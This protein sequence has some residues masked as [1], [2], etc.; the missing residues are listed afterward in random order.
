M[1]EILEKIEMSVSRVVKENNILDINKNIENVF[2]INW[3]NVLKAIVIVIYVLKRRKGKREK[4][5][6]E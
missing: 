6:S 4:I 1:V 5:A 2:K 3:V